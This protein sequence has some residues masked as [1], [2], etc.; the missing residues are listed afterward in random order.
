MQ[1]GFGEMQRFA[2]RKLSD[3]ESLHAVEELQRQILDMAQQGTV[4][5][6]EPSTG[7]AGPEPCAIRAEYS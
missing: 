7:V 6:G 2:V 5:S 1:T 3:L 4:T